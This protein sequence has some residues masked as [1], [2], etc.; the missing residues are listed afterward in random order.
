MLRDSRSVAS[1]QLLTGERQSLRT[2]GGCFIPCWVPAFQGGH[3]VGTMMTMESW[4]STCISAPE[5]QPRCVTVSAKTGF[6]VRQK[7]GVLP[8]STL[9]CFINLTPFSLF[10]CLQ[11]VGFDTYQRPES[12]G[13]QT[14]YTPHT[15]VPQARLQGEPITPCP[16]L[17]TRQRQ[18]E[19]CQA[20]RSLV[21]P[22]GRAWGLG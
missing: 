5:T 2:F 8:R 22:S 3:G 11:K 21:P 19:V 20:P 18:R 1:G 14:V 4:N 9:S 10:S 7:G 16:V 12:L 6:G 13:N 15:L 17:G